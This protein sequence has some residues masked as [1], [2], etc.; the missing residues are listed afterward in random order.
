MVQ[1]LNALGDKR[2]QQRTLLLSRDWS[3]NSGS[4]NNCQIAGGNPALN[5]PSHEE[6]YDLGAARRSRGVRDHE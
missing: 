6:M 2:S 5:Q 4:E 3:M 1:R